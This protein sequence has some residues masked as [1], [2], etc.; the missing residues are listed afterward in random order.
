MTQHTEVKEEVKVK[1]KSKRWM[2]QG[3]KIQEFK[4]ALVEAIQ[5]QM[6]DMP[7]RFH[8]LV[9]TDPNYAQ[10]F[11]DHMVLKLKTQ[12]VLVINET[13]AMAMEKCNIAEDVMA[14]YSHL[15]FQAPAPRLEQPVAERPRIRGC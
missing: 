13:V 12:N 3:E 5:R 8:K 14:L 11:A 6:K 15:E 7:E 10:T 4:D 1:K 9:H 2:S